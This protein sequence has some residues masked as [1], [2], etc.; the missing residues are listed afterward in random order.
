MIALLLQYIVSEKKLEAVQVG[1]AN[2]RVLVR[3]VRSCT[4]HL[5]APCLFPGFCRTLSPKRASWP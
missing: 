5:A 4:P 3:G 2:F 1:A